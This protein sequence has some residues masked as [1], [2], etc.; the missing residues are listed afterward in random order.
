[1]KP[2]KILKNQGS[3]LPSPEIFKYHAPKLG[4]GGD[5]IIQCGAPRTQWPVGRWSWIP[6]QTSLATHLTQRGKNGGKEHLV[7]CNLHRKSVPNSARAAIKDLKDLTIINF[8][9]N[10]K[11]GKQSQY[12][13]NACRVCIFW[14]LHLQEFSWKTSGARTFVHREK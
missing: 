14:H 8:P 5:T 4:D 9:T 12:M 10:H 2:L 6:C 7:I 1:M 11:K 3:S 13:I